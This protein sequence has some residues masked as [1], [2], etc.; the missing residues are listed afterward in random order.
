MTTDRQI[1][2][3]H[4]VRTDPRRRV[5]ADGFPEPGSDEYRALSHDDR[6]AICEARAGLIRGAP[7]A[8]PYTARDPIPNPI[9]RWI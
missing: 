3:Q 2:E 5:F 6:L 4:T 7:R 8:I 1:I 9:D